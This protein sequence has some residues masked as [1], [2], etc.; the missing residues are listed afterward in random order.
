MPS[1][2][3]VFGAMPFWDR[4]RGSADV[5]RALP[6]TNAVVVG[7]LVAAF[8][9]PVWTSAITGPI[10]IAIAAAGLGLLLS[11][12]VSP[13]VVVALCALGDQAIATW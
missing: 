7:I 8:I 9:T 13:I 3:L 5:R 11:G 12:R 1:F 6:G 2:L 10:D 4:L